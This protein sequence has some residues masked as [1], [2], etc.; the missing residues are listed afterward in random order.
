MRRL[1][2]GLEQRSRGARFG[3]RAG[4]FVSLAALTLAACAGK[5]EPRRGQITLALSSDMSLPKDVDSIRI[6]VLVQGR[7]HFDASYDVGAGRTDAKMPATL[8]IVA[9][10]DPSIPVEIRVLAFRNNASEVRTLNKTITTIPEGRNAMLRVPIQWLCTGQVTRV[11]SD[12]FQ[13]RCESD[14]EG[15]ETSCV[16]GLCEKVEVEEDELPDFTA[17]R[18]FGGADGAQGDGR[19]FPTE[20]CFD[21]AEKAFDVAP[22]LSDCTV[23]IEVPDDEQPNFA[24]L[25]PDDGICSGVRCYVPLDE[26][27]EDTSEITGWSAVDGAPGNLQRFA[28]PP[29]VCARIQS[30]DAFGVR[31]T[32]GCVTKTSATPPCGPWSSVGDPETDPLPPPPTDTCQN[33][34]PGQNVGSPTP[35][36]IVNEYLQATADIR[37]YAEQAKAQLAN[38]CADVAEALGSPVTLPNP[39]TDAALTAACTQAAQALTGAPERAEFSLLGGYCR[40]NVAA[41]EAC[42]ATCSPTASTT[43]EERCTSPSGVCTGACEGT[44]FTTPDSPVECAGS[45]EGVCDGECVGTCL[46]TFAA[47]STSTCGGTC[48]GTCNGSCAGACDTLTGGTCSGRCE[49][50]DDSGAMCE[51]GFDQAPDCALPLAADDTIEPVCAAVC[52]ASAVSTPPEGEDMMMQ[53][54]DC[55]FEVPALSSAASAASRALAPA[56]RLGQEALG[57]SALLVPVVAALDAATVTL[58]G[59]EGNEPYSAVCLDAS[60]R[61]LAEA[62][63]SLALVATSGG[64]LRAALGSP[65]G[66]GDGAGGAG[67]MGAGGS[68]GAAV[69]GAGGASAG[70]GGTSSCAEERIVPALNANCDMA[71]PDGA[72]PTLVNVAYSQ[73][74]DGTPM[75]IP[76]VPGVAQCTDQPAWY[77][78]VPADPSTITLCSLLCDAYQAS[79]GASVELG[80]GC[81]TVTAAGAGG[82]AGQ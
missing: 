5:S 38:A 80:V 48:V 55:S 43:A 60:S 8:A 52:M 4:L 1:S 31:A 41:Q 22:N 50:P 51:G 71:V 69:A 56:I 42:E 46:G 47:A 30:G 27:D 45:C 66:G 59:S 15:N 40:A 24:I 68:A 29:A 49:I 35:S 74:A 20:E 72:D 67:G 63:Q 78:D 2:T 70:A 82:Q 33:F 11:D 18:V 75:H 62:A 64:E 25:V 76:M 3:F 57:K 39:P 61:M 73:T 54:V 44:C 37:A 19:C 17:A 53:V 26:N 81:P 10:D 13:T 7:P 79:A 23:D 16:A 65:S 36:P 32:T 58:E 21:N 34:I 9:G 6:Q 77:Y 28:L 12:T 14:E